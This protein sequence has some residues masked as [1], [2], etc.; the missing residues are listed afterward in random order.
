[1]DDLIIKDALI[2]EAAGAP[3]PADAWERQRALLADSG[4]LGSGSE[5]VRPS[6]ANRPRLLMEIV[7]VAAVLLLAVGLGMQVRPTRSQTAQGGAPLAAGGSGSER[8]SDEE[9]TAQ[10]EEAAAQAKE[11]LARLKERM[12]QAEEAAKLREEMGRLLPTSYWSIA[13]HHVIGIEPAQ[14][15]FRFARPTQETQLD[16]V[17]PKLLEWLHWARLIREAVPDEEVKEHYVSLQLA[18]GDRIWFAQHVSC[19]IYTESVCHFVVGGEGRPNM[20]VDQPHLWRWLIGG[21]WQQDLLGIPTPA[22]GRQILIEASP[23][24]RIEV[25]RQ[26]LADPEV[27]RLG[28]ELNMVQ[29]S[30]RYVQRQEVDGSWRVNEYLTW[31]VSLEQPAPGTLSQI[32]MYDNDTGDLVSKS[33]TNVKGQ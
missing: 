18:G 30:P 31:I 4:L 7:A 17:V 27:Q 19:S 26:V 28:F 24:R 29:F 12:G 13:P 15:S 8:R 33:T 3:F 21:M 6:L 1:M 20:L 23:D 2:E 25:E 22:T 32:R 5:P 14:A 10:A 11:E 16:V 9:I